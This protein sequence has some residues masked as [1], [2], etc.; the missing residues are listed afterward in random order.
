[1]SSPSSPNTIL[2]TGAR[3]FIGS[4]VAAALFGSGMTVRAGARGCA[5]T[6]ESAGDM[7]ADA[8][9]CACDLDDFVQVRAAVAGAD[10]IVHAAY[11]SDAAMAQQCRTLLEA[12]AAE[13]VGSL[14][15]LSSIAVYGEQTGL[16]FEA[17]PPQGALGAYAAAKRQCEK[18][19]RDWAQ[20]ARRAIILRPGIVYGTGS[21]FWVDKMVERIRLGAWG[22][23][24][25]AGEGTAALIHI[26]DLVD[27]IDVASKRLASNARAALP[28]CAAL[29]AVGPE[30][31]SWNGYF[32]S[33]AAAI[34]APRLKPLNRSEISLREML[35]PLAKIWRRLGLPGA[36]GAALAATSGELALFSRKATYAMNAANDLLGFSPRID[37]DEGLA[38]T[39]AP[40]SQGRKI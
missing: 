27:L 6:H 12:M 40:R 20:G 15:Y 18:L 7:R 10:L 37:L 19:V 31:P 38:R 29:N 14:I 4:A 28:N 23:F 25:P 1:M 33:L 30:A 9:F 32:Q 16:V 2:V 22:D 34:G 3:G 35:S 11:G 36:R 21:Y 24:G 39:V 17:A 8:R 5:L 26:D 13:G